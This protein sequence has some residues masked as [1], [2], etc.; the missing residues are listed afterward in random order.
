MRPRPPRTFRR[1][2]MLRPFAIAIVL[3]LAL[4]PGFASAESSKLDP[5]ARIALAQLARGAS[6]PTLM[7]Q[8]MPV[9]SSGALDVFINGNV[10]REKLE[11]LGV[12]V[13]TVLPGVMTATIPAGAV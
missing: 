10:S 1:F 6:I 9:T 11:A 8:G 3:A 12:Q 7:E 13:R 4:V 2:S 5:R